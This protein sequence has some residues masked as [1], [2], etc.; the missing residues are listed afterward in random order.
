MVTSA[1]KQQLSTT[2]V[3][4]KCV[5]YMT[6]RQI[7]KYHNGAFLLPDEMYSTICVEWA[8]DHFGV[9]LT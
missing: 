6:D 4:E 1:K 3:N 2:L 9:G 8:D 7:D 5:R